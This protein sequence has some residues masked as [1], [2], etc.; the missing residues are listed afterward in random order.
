MKVTASAGG[1]VTWDEQAQQLNVNIDSVDIPIIS[2]DPSTINAYIQAPINDFIHG[3]M[4]KYEVRSF[5]IY[6]GYALLEAMK[7]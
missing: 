7:K 4:D 5:K 3:L 6:D 1:T 2:V